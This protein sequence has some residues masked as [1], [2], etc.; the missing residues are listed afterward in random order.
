M[1]DGNSTP[2]SDLTGRSVAAFCGIGN[3]EGFRRT[4]LPLCGDLL[5]LRIYPDHHD[6]TAA[7]VVALQRWASE[8]RADFVLTTQKDLVKLRGSSLGPV[9]LRA[10][11]IGL[12]IISG[13]GVM[14]DA[15]TRVLQK[16]PPG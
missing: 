12:D 9:P 1:I 16:I 8:V 14:E 13:E 3:P 6:Y 4:L 5:D 15:L 2:S 7:D 11:R 10:L